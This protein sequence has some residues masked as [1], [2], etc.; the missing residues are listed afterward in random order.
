MKFITK[1]PEP[2]TVNTTVMNVGGEAKKKSFVDY[3]KPYSSG[4]P[5][6]YSVNYP[7]TIRRRR[8]H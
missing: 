7:T 3:S 8:E 1:I 2:V 6:G 4:Y 5:T